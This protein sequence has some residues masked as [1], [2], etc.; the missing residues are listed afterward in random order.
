MFYSENFKFRST[1]GSAHYLSKGTI[2]S[3][4]RQNKSKGKEKIVCNSFIYSGVCTI[5]LIG[6]VIIAARS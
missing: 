6:V 3:L 4:M 5:I 2:G 1:V